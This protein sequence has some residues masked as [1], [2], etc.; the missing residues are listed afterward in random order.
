[1]F[2]CSRFKTFQGE[3]YHL[4]NPL[5]LALISRLATSSTLKKIEIQN[6]KFTHVDIIFIL[7]LKYFLSQNKLELLLNLRQW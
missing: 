7:F 4:I 5:Y 2:L 6:Q 1:M 3:K